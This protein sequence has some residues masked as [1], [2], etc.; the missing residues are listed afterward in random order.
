MA[1]KLVINIEKIESCEKKLRDEAASLTKIQENLQKAI[2][3]LTNKNGWD[4]EGSKLFVQKYDDSWTAGIN[5]RKA[6]ITRMAD[7]LSRAK[8]EYSAVVTYA[9][10]IKL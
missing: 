9:E 7:H 1:K 10:S 6:I 5:D 3:D 2:A 4:S 8:T